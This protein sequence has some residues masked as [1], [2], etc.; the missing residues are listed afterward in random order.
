MHE[1]LGTQFTDLGCFV[2]CGEI[3]SILPPGMYGRAVAGL[4]KAK[5]GLES[6]KGG[7]GGGNDEA[8]RVQNQ[9]IDANFKYDKENY[10]FNWNQP[11]GDGK[12]D[13]PG[14][15]LG[16]VWKK[17]NHTLEGLAIQKGNDQQQVDYQN[18]T[19][20]Q[21][22]EN[23]VSNSD[24][25]HLQQ[26]KLFEKSE[27]RAR[28]Q[29]DYNDIAVEQGMRREE[30]VLNE[31]FIDTAFN[32]QQMIQDMYDTIGGAGY[33]EASL[34]LGLQN[35]EGELDHQLQQQYTN[36]DQTSQKL[37]IQ[38]GKTQLDLLGSKA[39]AGIAKAE[40]GQDLTAKETN[41]QFDR[42][43]LGHSVRTAK[44]RN[45]YENDII[46]REVQDTRAKAAFDTVESQVQSLQQ[47]GQAQ[48]SQSGRSKGKAIQM[49][50]AQ[51]G[52]QQSFIA[53]TLVRGEKVASAKMVQQKKQLLDTTQKA[54]MA[55]Q[56]LDFST[57]DAFEKAR[58][59][60]DKIKQDL[61]ISEGKG[62]LALNEIKQNMGHLIE[63]TEIS[64]KEI[65]RN[66]ESAQ[67]QAG[68]GKS[69]ID[70]NLDSFGKQFKTD[71]DR[72]R[73]SLDSAVKSSVLAKEDLVNAKY[74]A[75][76][77]VEAARMLNPQT[78][79]EIPPP[80]PLEMMTYQD[81]LNP[82]VPPG[83]IK[84]AKMSENIGG[85]ISSGQ[86][87]MGGLMSG[88]SAGLAVSGPAGWAVGLGTAALS[89]L[90]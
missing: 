66:L 84:G 34:M 38:Q 79:P 59:G 25:I 23:Q 22:W 82:D 71:Q 31:A 37:G 14:K 9:Q 76:L 56:K 87:F 26:K 45:E 12:F 5:M 7:G 63:N 80:L 16:Q 19:M 85:G 3:R 50:L 77:E 68:L 58:L 69:K 48:L 42:A 72:M 21:N 78:P 28:A 2:E 51:F 11:T 73:A 60:M 15:P 4:D 74:A 43:A 90:V 81:P 40:I 6:R 88:I 54:A 47:Q 32:N 41:K 75:D 55:E 64:E 44:T 62:G 46:R 18:D 8:I 10:K 29:F 49:A 20:I 33:D 89:W 83:P 35:T 1:L 70:F 86:K 30:Q 36:L 53:D 27:D 39:G 52:R 13:D 65:N 24:Y 67:T 57:M 17:F 61:K